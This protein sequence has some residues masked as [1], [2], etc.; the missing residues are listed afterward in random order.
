[1][2]PRSLHRWPRPFL[3]GGLVSL[4]A[5]APAIAQ[6]ANF[7]SIVLGGD[8]RQGSA[9]GSTAGFFPLSNITAR[10]R[11]GN[12]CVG[13]ASQTPDHILVLQ[14]DFPSLKVRVDSGGE[15][16][17]LLIQGPNDNTVICGNDTSR[18]NLDAIV[19]GKNVPAGTYRVWVGAHEQGQQYNYTL[20]VEP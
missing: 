19:E 11:L 9:T 2:K 14:Q 16:T 12:L 17:T 8:V 1:M 18:R 5:I 20:V 13:F 7:G 6:N 10:D 4:L 15:D 3:L